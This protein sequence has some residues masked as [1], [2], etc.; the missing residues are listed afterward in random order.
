[1]YNNFLVLRHLVKRIIIIFRVTITTSYM[2]FK[3]KISK[4][5]LQQESIQLI[6]YLLLYTQLQQIFILNYIILM[7]EYKEKPGGRINGRSDGN[8]FLPVVVMGMILDRYP[9]IMII[10]IKH[11][12]TY[13]VFFDS[14]MH[15]KFQIKYH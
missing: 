15:I 10:F 4:Y 3:I 14:C 11:I 1:M 8:L 7:L 5:Y 9:K 6:I 2:S 13:P 12:N